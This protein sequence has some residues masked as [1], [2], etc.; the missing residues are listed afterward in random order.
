MCPIA[1]GSSI[2]FFFYASKNFNKFIKLILS[3]SIFSTMH[4]CRFGHVWLFQL[5]ATPWISGSS[6]HQGPLSMGFPRQEYW[7]GLPFPTPG[8]RP[9]PGIKPVSLVS[10]ALAGGFFTTEPPVL[11][12]LYLSWGWFHRHFKDGLCAGDSLR[13]RSPRSRPW[14]KS[15]SASK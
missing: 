9:H 5:C 11:L 6:A 13:M 15:V 14:D 12:P 8:D 1:C 4:V 2:M 10:L 3:D 7:S